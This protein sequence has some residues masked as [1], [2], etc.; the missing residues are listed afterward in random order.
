MSMYF[1]KL[2]DKIA[3]AKAGLPARKPIVHVIKCWMPYFE[4][5]VNGLK[6]FDVRWNDRDYR[7][8]DVLRMQ[9]FDPNTETQTEPGRC[10]CGTL[11]GREASFDV[12]YA[13]Y[14]DGNFGLPQNIVVMGIRKRAPW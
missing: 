5:C 3:D 6:T 14:G 4:D 7:V 12:R 2:D 8:G 9:E 11:T 13:L 10:T 1:D